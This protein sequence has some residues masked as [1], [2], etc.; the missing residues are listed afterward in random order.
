MKPKTMRLLNILGGPEYTQKT[1]VVSTSHYPLTTE[2]ALFN[3]DDDLY[4][5]ISVDALMHGWLLYISDDAEYIRNE[6]AIVT[7]AGHPELAKLIELAHTNDF[8]YLK[9][10]QD[11]CLL[12]AE[13]GFETFEW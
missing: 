7:A 13:L 3:E 8:N 10:D 4:C 6:V 5:H 2:T 1:L 12:P 9:L 11:G